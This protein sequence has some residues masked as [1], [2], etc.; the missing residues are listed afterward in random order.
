[1]TIESNK[2]FTEGR[3]LWQAYINLNGYSFQPTEKGLSKLSQD[4]ALKKT[5]LRQRINA[6]LSG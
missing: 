2:L 3:A 1:M 6:F 4:L 5:Y